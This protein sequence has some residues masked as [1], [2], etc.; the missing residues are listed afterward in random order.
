MLN[1][2]ILLFI[3]ILSNKYLYFLAIKIKGLFINRKA[4]EGLEF[5]YKNPVYLVSLPTNDYR[6]YTSLPKDFKIYYDFSNFLFP[7]LI[8]LKVYYKSKEEKK[9]IYY[10]KLENINVKGKKYLSN[11]LKIYMVFNKYYKNL[12]KQ[13]ICRKMR[14][15]YVNI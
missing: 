14:E 3:F 1:V 8:G 7:E 6:L 10:I 5:E 4:I 2:I 11:K 12:I 15:R 13:E 9:M